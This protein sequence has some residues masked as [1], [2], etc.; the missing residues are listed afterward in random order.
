MVVASVVF[1]ALVLA[2]LGFKTMKPIPQSE[3]VPTLVYLDIEPRPML[4][5]EVARVRPPPQSEQT[6]EHVRLPGSVTA[7]RSLPLRDPREDE[8]KDTPPAPPSPRIGAP[9]PG[10]A[11]APSAP[12]NGWTVRPES[13]GDRLA[14]GLRSSSVG[15]RARDLLSEAE[16][17]ICEDRFGEAAARAAP[18]VGSGDPDTDARFAREGRQRLAE[19]EAR[20][21][22]LA[23]GVGVVGP[24]D[25]PGSNFGMGVAGAH[26][27][28]SLRPD[29]TSNIRTRRDGPRSSGQ[30]L[31]P[32]SGFDR[33][34]PP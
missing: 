34:P 28:Q 4:D 25:G 31:T 15:C 23:G 2:G 18:L 16:R 5:G 14:R 30:P 22:P 3:P 24:Q 9:A 20:R 7:D 1:H 11:P 26:L 29:S 19:Y 8:D 13:Q 21:R 32:G 33:D 12:G 10:A 27:D 6:P 17:V